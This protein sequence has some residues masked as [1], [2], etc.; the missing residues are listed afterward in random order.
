MLLF[1]RSRQH[2]HVAR[3]PRFK[4]ESLLRG[5]NG[6]DGPQLAAKSPYLDPQTSA[7]RFVSE[8]GSK[9][10]RKEDFARN[11]TRPSLSE[12]PCERKKNR[13]PRQRDRGVSGA[14]HVT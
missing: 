10:S 6:S 5:F 3:A 12:C 8:F 4:F 2:N 1:D 13:P 11:I 14:H 7:M 9:R